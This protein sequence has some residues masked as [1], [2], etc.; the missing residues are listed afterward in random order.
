[1]QKEGD[2]GASVSDRREHEML[3]FELAQLSFVG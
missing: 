1:M 2:F 3:D